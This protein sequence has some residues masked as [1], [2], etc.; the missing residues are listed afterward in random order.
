MLS[1]CCFARVQVGRSKNLTLHGD[2]LFGV[3]AG[4]VTVV[5]EECSYSL[6]KGVSGS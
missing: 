1:L 4:R 5:L 2:P 3:K 6:E